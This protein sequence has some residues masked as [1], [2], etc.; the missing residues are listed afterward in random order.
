[1]RVLDLKAILGTRLNVREHPCVSRP[2]GLVPYPVTTDETRVITSI[3]HPDVYAF[4]VFFSPGNQD[5]CYS[6]FAIRSV[7]S[8]NLTI[9]RSYKKKS[10]LRSSHC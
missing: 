9:R 10:F 3:T 8:L 1:M 6:K 4:S 7:T 5:C 2:V